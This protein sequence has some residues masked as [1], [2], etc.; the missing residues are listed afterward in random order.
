MHIY[1]SFRLSVIKQETEDVT[2]DYFFLTQS[3]EDNLLMYVYIFVC[4]FFKLTFR[5]E[6]LN[7]YNMLE[8]SRANGITLLQVFHLNCHH[9][10]LYE[11]LC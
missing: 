11:E 5:I 2:S 6:V 8:L 1:L 7:T 9:P 4:L 3:D 10:F